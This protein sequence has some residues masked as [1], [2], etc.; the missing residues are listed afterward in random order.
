[1]PVALQSIVIKDGDVV[2]YAV[3]G[4]ATE[5]HVV[6]GPAGEVIIRLYDRDGRYGDAGAVHELNGYQL[7]QPGDAF[8]VVIE[9][10]S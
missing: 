7:S 2:R 9:E 8:R 10:Q 6:R 4:P 1:L 3:N 5:V